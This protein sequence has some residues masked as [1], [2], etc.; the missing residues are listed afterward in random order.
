MYFRPFSNF[1]DAFNERALIY[2]NFQNTLYR[3]GDCTMRIS[4]LLESVDNIIP[5][6]RSKILLRK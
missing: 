5:Q 1:Q 4:L 3:M 2:G 6:L